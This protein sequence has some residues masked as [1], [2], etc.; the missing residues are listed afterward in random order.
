MLHDASDRISMATFTW[1]C[2]QSRPD[3]RLCLTQ[4]LG[5]RPE[6]KILL[7]WPQVITLQKDCLI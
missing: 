2:N 5:C 7:P 3:Q 1:L 6:P 4:A